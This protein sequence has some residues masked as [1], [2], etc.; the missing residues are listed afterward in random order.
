VRIKF[1]WLWLEFSWF[2]PVTGQIGGSISHCQRH[3]HTKK[4]G[5]W[6]SDLDKYV[7][8]GGEISCHE[9]LRQLPLSLPLSVRLSGSRW[10]LGRLRRVH[11]RDVFFGIQLEIQAFMWNINHTTGWYMHNYTCTHNII[12]HVC[13][14]GMTR[15]ETIFNPRNRGISSCWRS[16]SS[17]AGNLQFVFHIG[18]LPWYAMIQWS[19][20]PDP[21]NHGLV[22]ELE[23]LHL[24]TRWTP[25]L[26]DAKLTSFPP[27]PQ[28]LTLSFQVFGENPW[29]P[30]GKP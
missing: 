27:K 19:L 13:A 20:S 22:L 26:V 1:H 16:I 8:V 23:S 14:G 10:C 24:L 30:I 2:F 9:V 11:F 5:L 28:A 18:M 21:K 6:I 25:S 4:N 7:D 3:T 29:D 12:Q 15:Q 17:I